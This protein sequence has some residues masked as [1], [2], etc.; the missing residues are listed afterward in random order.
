MCMDVS[1][2]LC[3]YIKAGKVMSGI[4]NVEIYQE[5]QK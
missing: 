3:V 2:Y 4:Y 1:V 5:Q